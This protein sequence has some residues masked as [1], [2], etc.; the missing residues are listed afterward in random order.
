MHDQAWCKPVTGETCGQCS[1]TTAYGPTQRTRYTYLPMDNT[2]CYSV[3]SL[4]WT[5]YRIITDFGYNLHRFSERHFHAGSWTS[6]TRLNSSKFHCC[7]IRLHLSQIEC[8]PGLITSYIHN[9]KCQYLPR[10]H[11]VIILVNV[12]PFLDLYDCLFITI[13]FLILAASPGF[14]PMS[15]PATDPLVGCKQNKS[16]WYHLPRKTCTAHAVWTCV[17]L[18]VR[19]SSSDTRSSSVTGW[20]LHWLSVLAGLTGPGAG[21]GTKSSS[22]S[23]STMPAAAGSG[24]RSS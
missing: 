3:D 12:L 14:T 1:F 4:Q 19:F 20:N 7:R 8:K 23:W 11:A 16:T 18:A 5:V 17:F 6:M 2:V 13:Y 24:F 9:R 21:S 10:N 15:R 22:I